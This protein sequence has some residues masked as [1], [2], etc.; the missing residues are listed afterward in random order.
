[1]KE[2]WCDHLDRLVRQRPMA[3]TALVAFRGMAALLDETLVMPSPLGELEDSLR[4]LKIR[5]GF[6]LFS[7]VDLPLDYGAAAGLFAA[8]LRVLGQAER[9]DAEGLQEALRRASED[10]DWPLAI[11]RAFLGQD[12]SGLVSLAGEIFLDPRTLLFLSHFS[13]LPWLEGLRE[14]LATSTYKEG[15]DRG[16]CPLCGSP[17]DMAYLGKNG[18]RHLHC[19]L[20]GDTWTFPRI[21]CPFCANEEQAT[22][23]V[24]C[25]EG[26][27][28]FRVDTCTKCKGYLKTVDTRSL[29]QIAPLEL[30]DLA[31]LHLDVVAT[32]RRP[33]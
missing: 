31:T 3:A 33:A 11:F 13:L 22:L 4:G 10:P 20:C 30:E 16:Y 18:R 28:G 8:F 12:T 6:P 9:Q 15:W 7:R 29:E 23:E 21:G 26:E 2:R 14:S 25:V 19:G 17:P 1:M 32:E 24:L 27:E 5:E